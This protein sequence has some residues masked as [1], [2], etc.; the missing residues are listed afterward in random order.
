MENMVRGLVGWWLVLPHFR[1]R[2]EGRRM[3]RKMSKRRRLR[4]EW[5]AV[6]LLA[7][8]RRMVWV[9]VSPRGMNEISGWGVQ[10]G[11]FAGK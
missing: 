3:G 2:I 10:L 8:E 6:V 11:G 5:K 4:R 9:R 7:K 1:G